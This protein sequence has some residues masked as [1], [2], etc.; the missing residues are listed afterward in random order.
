MRKMSHATMRMATKTKEIIERLLSGR[1]LYGYCI[2]WELENQVENGVVFLYQFLKLPWGSLVMF[3]QASSS[4]G[5]SSS[6]GS[7]ANRK[8][9]LGP[10]FDGQVDG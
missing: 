3:P 8:L 5:S 4:K 1:K 7:L 6:I 10:D 9:E 2:M